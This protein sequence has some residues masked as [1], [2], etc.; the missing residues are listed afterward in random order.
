MGNSP[1]QF[2]EVSKL[3]KLAHR[4]EEADK[5]Y[6][7]RVT[8]YIVIQ[9]GYDFDSNKLKEYL[10]RQLPGFK[11]PKEFVVVED[12]PKNSAGKILKRELKKNNAM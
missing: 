9:N 5:E 6:G 4:Q 11:I 1:T 3:R 2:P 7:E 10:K 12:I 8:A